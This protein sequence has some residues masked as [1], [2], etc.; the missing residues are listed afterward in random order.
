MENEQSQMQ[1][2]YKIVTSEAKRLWNAKYSS[3]FAYLTIYTKKK[4]P[5]ALCSF[6]HFRCWLLIFLLLWF[7]IFI[8][9]VAEFINTFG[10]QINGD[11]A[12]TSTF[13]THVRMDDC[14]SAHIS[15]SVRVVFCGCCPQT[16]C[17]CVFILNPYRFAYFTKREYNHRITA[18]KAENMHS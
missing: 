16:V 1:K 14:F 8:H 9:I 13:Y 17:G 5:Y 3:S 11:A 12:A 15:M 2:L 4:N 18:S 7:R 10:G 6:S